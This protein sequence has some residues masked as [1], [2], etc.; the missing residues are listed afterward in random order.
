MVKFHRCV[1]IESYRLFSTRR[2]RNRSL[3]L[4]LHNCLSLPKVCRTEWRAIY[5]DVSIRRNRI[6]PMSGGL[7]FSGRKP[8]STFRAADHRD[9]LREHLGEPGHCMGNQIHPT[10]VRADRPNRKFRSSRC[11]SVSMVE[12]LLSNSCERLRDAFA[13]GFPRISSVVHHRP[14]GQSI[15]SIGAVP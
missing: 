2:N 13:A 11:R 1:N 4:A 5:F 9:D 8:D 12:S 7:L 3:Q 10:N 14:T 6:Y 15:A